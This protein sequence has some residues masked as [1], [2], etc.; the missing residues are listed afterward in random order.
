M[1]KNKSPL[2]LHLSIV[3]EMLAYQLKIG[4]WASLPGLLIWS[5]LPLSIAVFALII[6]GILYSTLFC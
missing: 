1:S 4:R 3:A 5:V 6:L 2:K